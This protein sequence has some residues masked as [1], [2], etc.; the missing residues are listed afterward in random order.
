MAAEL[1]EEAQHDQED[2]AMQALEALESEEDAAIDKL[3][4]IQT[5]DVA[6][7]E[8]A[9]S[10]KVDKSFD[11]EK[12]NVIVLPKKRTVSKTSTANMLN[13]MRLFTSLAR[14]DTKSVSLQ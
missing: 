2:A 7:K 5:K 12:T 1:E 3:A 13:P 9:V 10:A 8:Q 4:L 14:H 6:Y 11:P